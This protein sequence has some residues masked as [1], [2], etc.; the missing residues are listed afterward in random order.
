MVAE[1]PEVA[2]RFASSFAT[3]RKLCACVRGCWCRG[4][5]ACW[6]AGLTGG[7]ASRVAGW[8]AGGAAGVV[9]GFTTPRTSFVGRTAEL[10]T[11]TG[12]LTEHR[13]VTVTGPGGVGKTRLAAAV[14]RTVADRFADGVWLAELASVADPGLVASAVA[15]AL[16]LRLGPGVGLADVLGRRQLLVVLDNCEHVVAAAAALCESLLAAADDIRVLTTSREPLGVAG[17]ARFRLRPLAVPIVTDVTGGAHDAGAETAA[18]TLFADRARLADPEFVLD[19]VTAP[20]VGQIVARLDGVPLAIELAAARVEGLGLSQ[21]ASRLDT[22]LALLSGGSRGAA[23]G[24]QA[25]LAATADWSYRLLSEDEQRVFR[26][27]SVFPGPFTLEAAEAVAGPQAALTVPRLV[28]CSLV[29]PPRPGADGRDRYLMLETLR[30]FGQERLIAAGEDAAISTVLVLH[31]TRLAEQ[32]SAELQSSATE[33]AGSAWLDAEYATLQHALVWAI[34]HDH[35]LSPR[36]A[37]ALV[38]WWWNRSRMREGYDQLAAATRGLET[39][40]DQWCEAQYWLCAFQASSL[41]VLTGLPHLNALIDALAA[42]PPVP[43]L[44][45]ALACRGLHLANLRRGADATADAQRG[46]ELALELGDPFAEALALVVLGSVALRMDDVDE[47]LT[48][49]LRADRLDLASLPGWLARLCGSGLSRALATADRRAEAREKCLAVLGS[50]RQVAVAWDEADCL[51]ILASLDVR[52]GQLAA[53]RRQLSEALRTYSRT[54]A[55]FLPGDLIRVC[56]SLVIHEQ[57]W[58]EFVTLRAA[59]E[60]AKQRHSYPTERFSEEL[61]AAAATA[62]IALSAAE[63]WAAE[64]RGAV[65]TADATAGYA[66]EV[67][68]SQPARFDCE[69][70]LSA[71]ERELVVLVAQGRSDAQIAS[72]LFISVSTVRSHLDRIRDK[73][74]CRRRADLTRLALQAGLL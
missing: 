27:L 19:A 41:D 4:G 23:G 54:G 50:A 65:M 1:Y 70:P 74:G 37:L 13:L 68:E 61:D 71:R 24:R 47:A 49:L 45:R 6:S 64:E 59:W 39:G 58:R 16:G 31:A 9:H 2:E 30:E 60:A 14:A 46:L 25:S 32:A 8:A 52:E 67:L 57:R 43:W 62:G 28:D 36:L 66:L 35:E 15:N 40:T 22:G 73:T 55:V 21:L 51:N 48:W 34:E 42:G 72:Q 11:V 7:Y 53:A 63:V 29:V 5:E 56:L 20:V 12:L 3:D 38:P 69:P 33:A 44:A 10:S 18:V 17:E 26:A